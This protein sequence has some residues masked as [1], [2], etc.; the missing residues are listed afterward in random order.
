MREADVTGLDMDM[1]SLRT[2]R[3]TL[4]RDVPVIRL[5]NDAELRVW[6]ASKCYD[7]TTVLCCALVVTSEEVT[8]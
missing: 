7:F 3:D 5:E 4:E 2:T 1:V 6:R 8:Y